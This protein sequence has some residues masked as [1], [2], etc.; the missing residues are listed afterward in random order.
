MNLKSTSL[1][2]VLGVALICSAQTE[3]FAEESK[4][5]LGQF[6]VTYFW[7]PPKK[8]EGEY[9][10]SASTRLLT[11]DGKLIKKVPY[12]FYKTLKLEGAGI[13]S[14]GRLV[15]YHST[16]RGIPR[17]FVGDK[18][19]APYGY[20]NKS[21][22]L[23]PYRTLAVDQSVVP[24]GTTLFI[25]EVVGAKLPDGTVHDGYFKAGD[26]GDKIKGNRIDIFAGFAHTLSEVK[27][28][29]GAPSGLG[30]NRSGAHTGGGVTI[31]KVS[32]GK[33]RPYLDNPNNPKGDQV[34]SAER[35]EG[36]KPS[37]TVSTSGFT[38]A[39]AG[40]GWA[41]STANSG[42]EGTWTG[43]TT[44][45]SLNVRSGP[46]SRGRNVIGS[47]KRGESFDILER[48]GNWLKIKFNGGEGWVYSKYVD[49]T[50]TEAKPETKPS[51]PATNVSSTPG[52]GLGDSPADDGTVNV[53]L[54]GDD[55]QLAEQFV[56]VRPG[57][58]L[59][60]RSGPGTNHRKKGSLPRGEKLQVLD[61]D[62][63]WSKVRR[64][65]GDEGWVHNDY[66][67]DNL[68]D[69]G[70]DSGASTPGTAGTNGTAT[71]DSTRNRG[72]RNQM[73]IGRI[74]VNGNTYTYRS[75]G[76]GRGNLPAGTYTVTKHLQ[77][78]SDR[79][80]SVGGVGYSFAV[81]DKY[82]PRVRGTRTLLRIHPDGGSAG[83]EGCIGIVGNAAT[84]RAFR[85]DMN[86]EID[87]N[88]GS[89]RLRVG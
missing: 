58:S 48:Q 74:T 11:P 31:Y 46:T 44:A 32:G 13:L 9:S 69:S 37:T 22:A 85:R 55:N 49:E 40:N 50:K 87:R 33:D 79:S 60:F 34:V 18:G 3:S 5:K 23:V 21:N 66:L 17:F 53:G 7:T 51:S 1:K 2:L 80:M 28:L 16:Q 59:S 81:S 68:N 24:F 63:S 76:F 38:G 61:E 25:P 65:N 6:G 89:Y 19:K 29:G 41:R 4:T 10:G 57:S 35:T 83:T 12:G 43:K 67:S 88:G 75:G 45:S 70:S 30:V 27:Q 20:G 86:A 54:G 47:L 82:D 78:R 36:E 62:G 71:F 56:N 77:N 26:I 84:Q 64:S 39:L 8:S 73:K 52:G 14:D 15:N 72:A 42:T